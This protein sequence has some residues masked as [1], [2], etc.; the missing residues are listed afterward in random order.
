MDFVADPKN[1]YA[2]KYIFGSEKRTNLLIHL[3]NAVLNPPSGQRV[4]SVEIRNPISE[5]EIVDDKQVVLDI[6]ARDQKGREFNVEMQMA[7]AP[8]LPK[9]I[10]YYWSD[11]YLKQVTSGEDFNLLKLTISICF[12]DGA[13]FAEPGQFHLLFHLWNPESQLQFSDLMEIHLLQ[14]SLFEKPTEDLEDALETWLYFLNNGLGM[15]YNRLPSELKV[16]EYQQ[17]LRALE[18]VSLDPKERERYEAREKAKR[19]Q[20]NWMNALERSSKKAQQ[21]EQKAKQAEQKVQQA[22]Q[23]AKQARREA[24]LARRKVEQETETKLAILID[25]IR[26][27]QKLLKQTPTEKKKLK[28]S[29]FDELKSW[30]TNFRKGCLVRK[31]ADLSSLLLPEPTPWFLALPFELSWLLRLERLPLGS[32]LSP[33][34]CAYLVPVGNIL[35]SSP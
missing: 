21:A 2:F 28:E 17:A 23:K 25:Q 19:D 33:I 22:E 7:I 18:M 29:S 13:L 31:S 27:Y 5:K 14:L 11:L 8:N 30:P 34:L 15:D 26:V 24:Q 20:L 16:P 1:D 10:L 3:L 35:Q 6:K 32:D 4:K 9:R 12:L